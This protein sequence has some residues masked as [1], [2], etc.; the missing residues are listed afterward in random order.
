MFRIERITEDQLPII[1]KLADVAFP[2][3]YK[4]IL[5]PQQINYMMEWMYSSDS[6]HKQMQ[7]GQ[8]FFVLFENDT[9]VGFVTVEPQEKQLYHLQK[10]YV[11]PE[12]QGK[13]AGKKLIET[14]QDLVR[15]LKPENKKAI[16]ELNVNRSNS[17][18]CFYKKM[19]FVID[20]QGDFPIGDG[21]YMNDY[22]MKKEI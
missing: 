21:Y 4:E 19:G 11:L 16:L 6:L 18:V 20:R 9:P 17:A 1:R 3:T 5:S 15:T 13:G 7:E 8:Y 12:Y 2:H 14:A 22:I 10:I